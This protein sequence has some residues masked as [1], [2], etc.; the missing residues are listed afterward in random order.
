MGLTKP[1]AEQILNLDYKQA[2]RVITTTNVNLTGGAPAQVDGVNLSL[3]DR[4]LVTGQSTGSENGIYY[5]E[6]LGTGSDGTWLRTSDSNTTGEIEA[7][8]IIMVT[9]GT[10]Y[11]DTQW[12]LITNNPITIGVTTL[13]FV[14][15][16]SANSISG[17]TSNVVVYSSSNVTV[18][19][20]GAANVLTI[21]NTGAYVSGIVSA[22]GNIT[23]NYYFGNGSQLTGIQATSVGTLPSLSVTGNID[24]GNLRTDGVVSATGNITGNYFIGNG[25]Q[26]T[27]VTSYSDANVVSLLASFGSNNISTTG[28]ITAGN[29]NTPSADLA[30]MYVADADY[31][32]GTVVEFGGENEITVTRSSHSP[33]AAGVVST[34]PGHVMNSAQVGKHVLPVALTGRVPCQVI[35]I[36]AK[37]DRLVASDYMGAAQRL[38]M[39]KYQPGCIIGKSLQDY[40]SEHIG[41]IEI[42]VGRF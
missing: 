5:V 17:G 33:R 40:N 10:T 39:S 19:S 16:Y 25:S 35:G 1:R 24:A 38:D 26:L 4:V 12:K 2:T 41:I 32:A 27:G 29:V 36:I 15:N 6:V 23:G 42:A 34:D 37:G 11:A 31:P 13:T 20:N 18:S 21:S 8:M 28:N 14:Q 7:G 22:T 9:E 3:D 30:E